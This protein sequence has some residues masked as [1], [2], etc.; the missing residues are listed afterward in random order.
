M[1]TVFFFIS[2]VLW[3]A[4]VARRMVQHLHIMQQNSYRPERFW[5]WLKVWGGRYTR[6]IDLLGVV[7]L[8]LSFLLSDGLAA[9]G[10]ALVNLYLLLSWQ[11]PLEKKPLVFTK[12][13]KR[14]YFAADGLAALA[15]LVVMF[16]GSVWGLLVLSIL[17]C[18]SYV[19]MLLAAMVMK[20]IEDKINRGF[21]EDAKSI[22]QEMPRL[23][24]CAVT[25][26][27]GKTSTK[28]VLGQVLSEEHHTMITPEIYNTPMGLTIAIRTMLKPTHEY[29]V[30]ETGA[31]QPGDIKELCD[32]VQPKIGILTAI[33]RQ[34][35]ETFKTVENV[36]ET[37][38]ELIRALPEDG[39]AVLN[40]DNKYIQERMWQAKCKVLTCGME[41]PEANFRRY[42]HCLYPARDGV[43][44]GLSP[45]PYPLPHPFVGTA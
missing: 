41:N 18:C 42:G 8:A 29:F 26:S 7:W 32:L 30:A 14:L 9:L 12:R 22:I 39:L 11:R 37:K 24:V 45:G 19:F 31:R 34:H 43:Y 40:L 13:A 25:G 3:L 16:T 38:F 36:A 20:P 15:A 6:K 35:L 33:G 1:Y 27:Y 21:M 2:I 28:V 17:A 23:T 4:Y 5:R 44:R 10:F